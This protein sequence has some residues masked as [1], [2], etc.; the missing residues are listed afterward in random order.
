MIRQVAHRGLDG[1]FTLAHGHVRS[2]ME[3]DRVRWSMDLD[4]V[5]LSIIDS[6]PMNSNLQ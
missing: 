1:G 6:R 2:P 4:Y 3:L 5:R